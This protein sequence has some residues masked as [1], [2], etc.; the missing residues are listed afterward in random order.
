MSLDYYGL[1]GEPITREEW[2][3]LL[4][5]PAKVL[6]QTDLPGGAWVSTVWLGLDHSFGRGAPMLFESMVFASREDSTDLDCVRYS[7]R[8]DAL[9]GHD[10]LVTRWTGWTPGDPRPDEAQASFLTQF[11]EAWSEASGVDPE[12]P[13]A[14]VVMHPKDADPT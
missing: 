13:D 1:N 3:R 5:D 14:M 8:E 10:V 2:S 11:I 7:T 6:A 12:W 9:L 4:A